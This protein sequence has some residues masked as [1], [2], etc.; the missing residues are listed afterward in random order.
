MVLCRRAGR[1][2]GALMSTPPRRAVVTVAS[3][4]LRYAG[5][6]RRPRGREGRRR[7]LPV[8]RRARRDA[9]HKSYLG[10]GLP[11][12]NK[13]QDE[14]ARA[15]PRG[16]FE[17]SVGQE[18]PDEEAP[19]HR[20]VGRGA[21]YPRQGRRGRRLWGREAA[22]DGPFGCFAG[23][24]P[25]SRRGLACYRVG[26]VIDRSFYIWSFRVRAGARR[27]V[28][29]PSEASGGGVLGAVQ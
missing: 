25:G 5:R 21:R 28:N 12:F 6:R 17:G 23:E 26:R 13:G 27:G 9:L 2:D 22:A 4:P 15:G 11:P 18:G 3:T 29:S 19:R 7:A 24:G 20:R 16:A 10:V 14:E 8:P 1:G